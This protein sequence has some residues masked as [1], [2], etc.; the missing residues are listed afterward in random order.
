M[1]L[2]EQDK[3][4]R[5]FTVREVA[6]FLQL[7]PTTIVSWIKNGKI[8]AVKVGHAWRIKRREIFRILDGEK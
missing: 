5:P 6:E 2:S 8:K 7:K 3:A 1:A 4:E